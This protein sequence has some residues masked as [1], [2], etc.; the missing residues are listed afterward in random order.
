M[1]RRGPPSAFRLAPYTGTSWA[2]LQAMTTPTV[3]SA[4]GGGIAGSCL[5]YALTWFRER[6]RTI[7]SYRQPQRHAIGDIV[8]ATHQLLVA[9]GDLRRLAV[10]LRKQQIGQ[11]HMPV[12]LERQST[13]NR[14]IAVAL[15]GINRS[16]QAGKLAVVDPDCFEAMVVGYSEWVRATN[17][18]EEV[19]ES[20]LDRLASLS[21]VLHEAVDQLDRKVVELVN[22]SQDRVT[23]KQGLWSKRKRDRRLREL[24][25]R[26]LGEGPA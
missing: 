7:D 15:L 26:Y 9:E 8:A 25:L 19:T 5:T 20:G 13:V 2:M 6:R 11:A 14:D 4:I 21:N 22:V 16:F 23:P 17:A 3:I 12:T 1:A 10:D 24:Q 18:I